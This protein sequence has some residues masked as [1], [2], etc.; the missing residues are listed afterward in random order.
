[1]WTI[2]DFPVYVMGS[3]Q[4]INEKLTYPYCMKNNKAFLLTNC[5]KVFF[6]CHWRCLPSH[7]H[8]RKNRKDF[9]NGKCEKDVA[10][11][12][13]SGTELYKA[14]SQYEDIVFSFQPGKQKI[15][16]FGVIYN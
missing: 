11:F 1:M 16:S 5:S 4:S 12:V 13:L 8:Y 15:L 14:V 10:A 3:R 9:L 7:N 6:Y 2:N